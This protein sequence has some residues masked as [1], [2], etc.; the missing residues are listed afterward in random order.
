MN[1]YTNFSLTVKALFLF[2][3]LLR[4]AMMFSLE[5]YAQTEWFIP[6]F[7]SFWDNPS[8]DPWT[9]HLLISNGAKDFP[10]GIVMLVILLPTTA[11]SYFLGGD[12]VYGMSLGIQTTLLIADILCFIALMIQLNAKKYELRL[13]CLY[14]LSPLVLGAIY[15]SGQLDIIPITILFYSFIAIHKQSYR[16]AGILLAAAISA[17]FSM[18]FS[19][20][21][22]LIYFLRNSRMHPYAPV[23]L[24]NF[25][26]AI[27]LLIGIPALSGGYQK[28]VLGT[29]ELQRFFDLSLSVG[30]AS[31]FTTPILLLLILYAAWRLPYLSYDL[32]TAFMALVTLTIILTT[33]TP[34]G[35]F[36]WT[37]PF[38]LLHLVPADNA[39][40]VLGYVFSLCIFCSQVLFWPFPTNIM[41]LEQ[42]PLN[43]NSFSYAIC[44]T[45]IIGL[46]LLLMNGVLRNSFYRNAIFRFASKPVSI[47]IAGDSGAGKDTLAE[48]LIGLFGKTST[49]HISGD[50]YH[51]WDRKG[52]LWKI[53]TH[54]NPRANDIKRFYND[55]N[56]ILDKNS[57]VYRHY[58]HSNGCFSNPM[59][60]KSKNFCIASGLH[61]LLQK[62][63]CKRFDVRVFLEM[64]ESLRVFFKCSRDTVARN[65]TQASVL[66]SLQAR[67]VDSE[68][69]IV[70]Q[71]KN[72]D[73]VFWVETT[74]PNAI[75]ENNIGIP[76]LSLK[77]RLRHALF[78]EELARHLIASCGLNVSVEFAEDMEE[79]IL[80]IDGDIN[81]EDVE[82][83]ANASLP[84]IYELLAVQP[85]WQSGVQGIMQLIVLYQLLQILKVNR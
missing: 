44:L 13:V 28:M 29:N 69:Y 47:G 19:L 57:I 81:A 84:E 61:T 16:L 71:Q 65:H 64:D 73:I 21:F 68:K 12:S 4:I 63:L 10:Y 37:I 27:V 24:R 7:T 49:V 50:D 55:I 36:I 42:L 38:L 67:A 26:I 70:P 25:Y 41:P 8:L 22:L 72:A 32:L 83:L 62:S 54:L 15:W 60:L 80:R 85:I 20:P 78:Y 2:G 17:K 11:I 75:N 77:V 30:D 66:K 51:L 31:I 9:S 5:P 82:A 39:Q 53:I 59:K 52:A 48:S 74:T 18:S 46:G 23:F 45:T 79:I 76:P 14:W 6:F 34:P 35:W 3:L 58:Q 1:F 56:L 33:A 40:R 43:Q